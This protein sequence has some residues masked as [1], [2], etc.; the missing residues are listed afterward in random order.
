MDPLY[1]RPDCVRAGI[2]LS[3]IQDG[4]LMLSQYLTELRNHLETCPHCER[5]RRRR[6]IDVPDRAVLPRTPAHTIA[7][8]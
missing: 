1:P 3:S 8:R 7:V 6:R 5:S 2:V 4:S